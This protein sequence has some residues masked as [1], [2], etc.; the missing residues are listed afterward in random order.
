MGSREKSF[1]NEDIGSYLYEYFFYDVGW[2]ACEYLSN[3][4]VAVY[5]YPSE[6]CSN[7]TLND[8]AERIRFDLQSSGV[9]NDYASIILVSHSFGGIVGKKLIVD[10]E[11]KDRSKI[12]GI[13]LLGVHSEGALLADIASYIGLDSCAIIRDLKD[14]D[15]NSILQDVERRWTR[16]MQGG[17]SGKRPSVRCMFE[18]LPSYRT[19]IILPRNKADQFC[20]GFKFPANADHFEIAAP[21]PLS[22]EYEFIVEAIKAMTNDFI[23]YSRLLELPTNTLFPETRVRSSITIKSYVQRTEGSEEQ[24]IDDEIVDVKY[25][26]SFGRSAESE[27]VWEPLAGCQIASGDELPHATAS[28]KIARTALLPFD[29]EVLLSV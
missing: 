29:I 18:K 15:T 3:H 13:L 5:E 28:G 7:F 12:V 19:V 21:V 9:F 2:I 23:H 24:V 10:L 11:P 1:Y 16:L 17:R 26:N 27:A 25:S 14:I 20:D 8:I 6:F 4:D 22:S